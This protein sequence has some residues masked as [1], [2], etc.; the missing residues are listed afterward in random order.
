MLVVMGRQEEALTLLK[1]KVVYFEHSAAIRDAVGQLLVQRG[2]YREAVELLRQA[3]IL[4]NTDKSIQEHLALAQYFAGQS[5]DAAEGL[6][7][8]MKE[9][10]YSERGDLFLAL[11]HC[12][13]EIGQVHEAR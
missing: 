6:K 7:V 3:R 11:G 12:Q 9:A 13:M 4:D 8:L 2:E 1:D 10:P 5:R